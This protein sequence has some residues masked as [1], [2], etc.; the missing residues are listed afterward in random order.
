[1]LTNEECT[2]YYIIEMK[3]SSLA[4]ITKLPVSTVQYNVEKLKKTGTL[5][6]RGG[7]G[8]PKKVKANLRFYTVTPK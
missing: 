4:R 6:H 5:K 3:V 8:R 2:L 1:M 7:N